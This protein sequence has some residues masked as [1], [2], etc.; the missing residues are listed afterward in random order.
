MKV[1]EE[2]GR[3]RGCWR[4]WCRS[5]SLA[6]SGDATKFDTFRISNPFSSFSSNQPIPTGLRGLYKGFTPG[7]FGVLQGTLQIITY[8]Q[9]KLSY[10]QSRNTQN[11]SSLEY[12]S[13][14]GASKIL[15]SML[16]YPYQVLKARMQ[17][18]HK[19]WGGWWRIISDISR[20]EGP[21]GFY[22][23]LLPN[24]LHVLPNVCIVFLIYE[25][26][27]NSVNGAKARQVETPE[28]IDD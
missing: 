19:D 17:D 2:S 26:V 13:C 11:L 3:L 27:V 8:N 21:R 28:S 5:W 24:L 9:L 4:E 25:T 23:G 10:M 16:T 7:L 6:I 20:N 12:V 1:G 15:S 18:Q 22:R 14:A